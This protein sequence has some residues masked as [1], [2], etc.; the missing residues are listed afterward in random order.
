MSL[1]EGQGPVPLALPVQWFEPLPPKLPKNWQSVVWLQAR[2]SKLPRGARKRAGASG[3]AQG[4]RAVAG[5]R[6]RGRRTWSGYVW[7][8]WRRNM[9]MRASVLRLLIRRHSP[10]CARGTLCAGGCRSPLDAHEAA[11]THMPPRS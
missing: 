11:R 10:A 9:A 3:G 1:V 8:S 6:R 2:A 4:W 5:R 7:G